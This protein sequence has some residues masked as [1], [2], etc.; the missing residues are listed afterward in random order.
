M[1]NSK[2]NPEIN[3][4]E[5]KGLDPE[6]LEFDAQ[7]WEVTM[8][9]ED[10]TIALGNPKY[11]HVKKNIIYYPI[12]LIK[13][14]QV[15]TQIGVYEIISDQLASLLDEDGDLDI[16]ALE[17]LLYSFVNKG[18]L[19]TETGDDVAPEEP[20][21]DEDE[22]EDGDEDEDKDEE[23]SE[24]EDNNQDDGELDVVGSIDPD[25]SKTIVIDESVVPMPELSSQTE[26][27]A[28][29]EREKV[30]GNR[31]WVAKFMGNQNYDITEVGGG[32]D[33]LFHVVRHALGTIGK[34]TSVSKLR[35]LLSKEA[36]EEIFQSY[37]TIFDSLKPS[38]QENKQRK[39]AL[40]TENKRLKEELKN[41]NDRSRQLEIIDRAKELK[42]E[43]AKIKKEDQST[44]SMY[45]EYKFMEGVTN[46]QG[47]KDVIK[48]CKFWAETWSISTLE[49]A[50]N[51]KLIL[52][53]R[54]HYIHGDMAN[55]L[56]CGQLNDA[57]LQQLGI[58]EPD[59]YIIANYTGAHYQC[60]EYKSRAIFKF[61][62]LPYDLKL[63]IC[64]R[65][66]EGSD[67]AG[68]YQIIP[69]FKHF[70]SEVSGRS[71]TDDDDDIDD[72]PSPSKSLEGENLQGDLYDDNIV[73]Q[74]YSK[75][76][77]TAP[78][79]G[80]GEKIPVGKISEFKDLSQ[81]DNWRKMLSNFAIASFECDGKEWLTVEHFYQGSK[82]KNTNGEN[83]FYDQ[84]SLDSQSEISKNPGMAKCAG[85]KTGK[86][87]GKL[88]RPKDVVMDVDFMG[89]R[90]DETMEKAMYSKFTQNQE[91]KTMLLATKNAKLV[92]F[93]RG[94]PVD[95]FYDLM[96]VRKRIKEVSK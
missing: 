61:K 95:V 66:M 35:T 19:Y 52:L 55:V 77:D 64:D 79:K 86:C 74:F 80:S 59:H 48:T 34:R 58:F 42:A 65:C 84:F 38:L 94:S 81:V 5:N 1:V 41:T 69:D 17:P 21:E 85:G 20:D 89:D 7:P 96:R 50:L 49:R 60:V 45:N 70:C 3:Y 39:K 37:K 25:N 9:G 76:S 73:F 78:G 6:D 88:V 11:K 15:D 40:V 92:H 72:D 90:R 43:Y 75:S 18:M 44:T 62:E 56:Q 46:L 12:Y 13:N 68:P 29:K 22:D 14:D 26:Q 24:D 30:T 23:P 51:I 67:Q 32:G 47:F 54:Q 82:F 16:D 33:C 91:F 10:I 4:I 53:S 27:D 2:L 8:L 36:S 31:P 87:K 83:G 93:V 63:K 28:A 57:I 71:V